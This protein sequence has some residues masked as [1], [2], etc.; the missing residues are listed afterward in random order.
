MDR[1]Y[2]MNYQDSTG[3]VTFVTGE[4]IQVAEVETTMSDEELELLNV[5]VIKLPHVFFWGGVVGFGI[6]KKIFQK[7]I[8]GKS[9]GKECC[10]L[11][12]FMTLFSSQK[13]LL[14][15]QGLLTIGFLQ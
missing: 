2:D 14:K 12:L 1:I 13:N 9:L 10:D 15:N 6:S 11:Y 4:A 3:G 5:A 8:P 7:L